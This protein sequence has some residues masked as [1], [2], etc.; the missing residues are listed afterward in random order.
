MKIK[1]VLAVEC[2]VLHREFN[3]IDGDDLLRAVEAAARRHH[4]AENCKRFASPTG[5]DVY[6]FAGE[7]S[8]L[9]SQNPKPLGP[10]G[11]QSALN[12]VFTHMVFPGAAEA[13]ADHRANSFVTLNVGVPGFGQAFLDSELGRDLV[14]F[15]PS[16][17]AKS[18]FVT[19]EDATR[20][21]RVCY[22]L[23]DFIIN[24]N[25]ACAVH[26]CVS[27]NLV[28]QE[29]FKAAASQIEALNCRPAF[30]S[31]AGRLAKR[32]PLGLVATG[33]QIVFGKIV[34]IDEVAVPP[35]ALLKVFYAFIAY[36]RHRGALIADRETFSLEGE[37]WKAGV[38]HQAAKEPG[39]DEMV[40][41]KILSFPQYGIHDSSGRE[42]S[43]SS[44][45]TG[46]IKSL[47]SRK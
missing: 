36:C 30:F 45:I 16:M 21:S 13:V 10:Q 27:D 40:R 11:F 8:I 29:T 41:I 2:A 25:P 7:Y 42:Q 17:A 9:V 35:E 23:S 26:W 15:D 43:S 38:L 31:S 1:P 6:V 14:Q 37:D 28:N 5:N 32:V 39:A 4:L 12:Q 19:S 22:E 24:H 33:S 47:F 44:G 46:R 3:P 20:A 34:S 18:A